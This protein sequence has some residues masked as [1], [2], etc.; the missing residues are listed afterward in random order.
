VLT[1]GTDP[2]QTSGVAARFNGSAWQTL[3]VGTSRILTSVW[4]PSAAD[5][6]VTGE[7]G[8]LLRFDG[9]SWQV[10]NTGTSELLW[11]VSGAPSGVGG[12]FAVGYNS[13]IVTGTT[14]AGMVAQRLMADTFGREA[15]ATLDPSATAR[16]QR[17]QGG[18]LPAGVAR[19]LR[20]AM[21]RR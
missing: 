8:T 2:T 19:R 9:T 13:T 1:V 6:Y 17:V 4:G 18:A 10:Q 16:G 15:S 7:L 14:G 11:A 3:N 21:R 5:V 12:A 20:L